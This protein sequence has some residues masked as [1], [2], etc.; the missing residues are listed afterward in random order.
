MRNETHSHAPSEA[1]DSRRADARRRFTAQPVCTGSTRRPDFAPTRRATRKIRDTSVDECRAAL[2]GG[3]PH[4]ENEEERGQTHIKEE[5]ETRA[6]YHTTM[7]ALALHKASASSVID[8]FQMFDV[9]PTD[10]LLTAAR[11]LEFTLI[12]Q[13]INPM[14][15]VVPAVDSFIDLNRSYFTMKIR[16][17][18]QNG[19]DLANDHLLYLANNLAHTLIKQLSCHLNGTLISP[20][21]DS[22]AHKAF[23]ETVLNYTEKVGHT[24]LRTQGWFPTQHEMMTSAL[25]FPTPLTANN[26]DSG[27]AHAHNTALSRTKKAAV[28]L[29]KQEQGHYL[30][31][32]I[33]TLIFKRYSEL[34]HLN[35]PLVPGVEIKLLF[36]FNSPDFF[37]EWRGI[38]RTS[39]HPGSGDDLSCLS[40]DPVGSVVQDLGHASTQPT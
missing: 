4:E 26:L 37:F 35:K 27:T 31:S 7:T 23:L 33:R 9:P 28:L 1:T 11:M 2:T 32:A 20:Q 17:K 5:E 30:G 40:T 3:T 6:G 8:A 24:L 25:D 36:Y 39:D 19:T 10:T 16:L 29:S 21:N 15:F 14:E 22:Y 18:Q 38:T 13:G 12:S 34:F